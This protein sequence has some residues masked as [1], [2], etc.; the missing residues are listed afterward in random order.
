MQFFLS[1]Q[2]PYF[3]I[4]FFL[5]L[6]VY[7]QS[8]VDTNKDAQVTKLITS[9][10]DARKTNRVTSLSYIQEALKL[11]EQISDTTRLKLYGA[12]G[13]I[14][15]D[16]GSFSIALDYFF[17]ELELQDKIDESKSFLIY[18]NI[19]GCYYQLG[20]KK[21][22]RQFLEK[23][24]R[25]F[26]DSKVS[27]EIKDI[28]A[29]SIYNNLALLE[30]EDGNLAKALEML[31]EFKQKNEQLKDTTNIILALQNL[32][33]L[34]IKLNEHEIAK[35]NL[36]NALK[37]AETRGSPYD[38]TY[39]NNS[40][41]EIYY[42]ILRETDS[43]IAFTKR[44]FD[45]SKKHSFIDTYLTASKNLADMYKNENNFKEALFYFQIEKS[46][47]E[48]IITAENKS[49]VEE[50][51][52]RYNKNLH[53]VEYKERQKKRELI[54][55]LTIGILVLFCVTAIL[56]LKLLRIKLKK[57]VSE[58]SVLETKLDNSNKNLTNS[59]LQ[60]IQASEIIENTGKKLRDI[61]V[62]SGEIDS[63][64]ISKIIRELK[65]QKTLFNKNSIEKLIVEIDA[66]FYKKL[67]SQYPNLT[68]NEIRLCGFLK[69]NLDTK[70]ISSITQQS[71][72]SI[73]VARYRLRKKLNIDKDQSLV[74]YLIQY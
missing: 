30:S 4:L 3:L 20:D 35:N 61:E 41:G 70:E 33:D 25:D 66:E 8:K 55:G 42:K 23:S 49:R 9:G 48:D 58:K 63:S 18:N 39:L 2:A 62:K 59:A 68:K 19:G 32:S 40:L 57:K 56:I 28:E 45:L 27:H 53:D 73:V 71:P 52:I 69:L 50:L 51:E 31:N 74:S 13:I 38:I 67:L 47:S 10:E 34:H 11:S 22:T 16:W 43:S 37:I 46:L 14:Y 60:M 1:R 36:R 24:V 26:R 21:K 44:A 65:N 5:P 64:K 6:F 7:G 29:Y 15:K 12:A 72:Q 54:L 17:K